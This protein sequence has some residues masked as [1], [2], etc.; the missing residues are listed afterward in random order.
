M[1][2]FSHI[3]ISGKRR[4]NSCTAKTS[5]V[6]DISRDYSQVTPK[7]RH[8]WNL[9]EQVTLLLL[10]ERY[11]NIWSE[12]KKIFNSYVGDEL[13]SPHDFSEGALRTMHRELKNKFSG[14][15]GSWCGVRKALENKATLLRVP[16]ID[17]IQASPP[18]TPLNSR[19][20]QFITGLPTP[21]SSKG[22]YRQTRIPRLGFRAF[23]I[24]NQGYTSISGCRLFIRN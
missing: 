15:F 12:K 10:T 8:K 23:D 9:E 20:G 3:E 18:R 2:Q 11:E 22:I 5:G 17:R 14:P 13:N 1:S 6:S 7:K 16:L 24:S 4:H 21:T 19:F